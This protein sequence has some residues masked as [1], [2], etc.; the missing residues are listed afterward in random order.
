MDVVGYGRALASILLPRSPHPPKLP[1][2]TLPNT[3]LYPELPP[4]LLSTLAAR[5]VTGGSSG[6]TV[7]R[8]FAQATSGLGAGAAPRAAQPRG[9]GS[10]RS[11]VGGGDFM[12]E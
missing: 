3:Q 9:R 4:R 1:I 2:P 10:I 5:R 8:S 6:L 12:Q 11:R 7:T